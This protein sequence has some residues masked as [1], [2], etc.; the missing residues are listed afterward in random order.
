[1]F[2]SDDSNVLF[3]FEYGIYYDPITHFVFTDYLVY[4]E[5]FK[6]F[7]WLINSGILWLALGVLLVRYSQFVLGAHCSNH[8]QTKRKNNHKLGD[9]TRKEF[10]LR[11]SVVSVHEVKRVLVSIHSYYPGLSFSNSFSLRNFLPKYDF[12][13]KYWVSH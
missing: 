13:Y 2:F 12:T 3:C 10:I 11:Y 1:M 9:E 8:V 4:Q 5:C 6:W 7:C